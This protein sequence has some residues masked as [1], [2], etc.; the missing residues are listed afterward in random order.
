MDQNPLFKTL[1]L[2]PVHA[3][4]RVDLPWSLEPGDEVRGKLEGPQCRYASTIEIA[5]PSRKV[6]PA[7]HVTIP[8]PS[9]WSPIAPFVYAGKFEWFRDGQKLAESRAV[10]GL[11]RLNANSAGLRLNGK[12]FEPKPLEVGLPTEEELLQFRQEGFNTLRPRGIDPL[13]WD[14]A[15]RVGFLIQVPEK[16]PDFL[17]GH[18]LNLPT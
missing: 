1:S 11:L 8:E 9:P 10:H 3:E 16:L 12:P 7:Y 5:Y 17:H 2:D 4:V 13:L 14:R 15:A 18:F 6:G